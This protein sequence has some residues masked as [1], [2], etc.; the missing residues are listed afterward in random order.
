[1]GSYITFTV[2]HHPSSDNSHLLPLL[3]ST[4]RRFID[5]GRYAQDIRYLK[6]WIQYAR[7]V[8]RREEIFSMLGSRE[9]GT[10]HALFYE[11]WATALEGLGRCVPTSQSWWSADCQEEAGRRHISTRHTS[12]SGAARTA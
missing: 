3:E 5:D 11:E 2:Q 9:I 10:K 7:H 6:L 4:N 12:Q 8:E 1:M